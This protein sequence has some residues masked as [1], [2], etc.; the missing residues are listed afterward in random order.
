MVVG[1]VVGVVVAAV[2]VAAAAAVAV[3]VAAVA[4]AVVVIVV[5]AAAPAVVAVVAAVAHF[6]AVTFLSMA[7]N[8]PCK[9]PF[10]KHQS[11][12]GCPKFSLADGLV[13]TAVS[14]AV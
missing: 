9:A 2:A 12:L 13:F 3:A 1:V 8:Q 6:M 11:P 5:A 10:E 4:V 14:L 7:I